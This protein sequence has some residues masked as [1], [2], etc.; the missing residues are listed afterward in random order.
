MPVTTDELID[1]ALGA[2][3]ASVVLAQ[4]STDLKNRALMAIAGAIRAREAEILAANAQDC[5]NASPRIEIDRLRLTPE[6]VA[7][8]ARDVE[9]VSRLADPSRRAVRHGHAAERSR[10]LEETRAA[11]RRRRRLRVAAECDERRR[12]DLPEDRQRGRAAG[13]QRGAGE[14]S[15]DCRGHSGRAEDRPGCRRRRCS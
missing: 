13:R 8:M 1:K 14:Q 11:G 2:K 9:A 12:G 7:G 10:D 5:A 4:A 15:R 6:R 3:A